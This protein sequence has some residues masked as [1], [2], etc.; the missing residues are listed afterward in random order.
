MPISTN[1]TIIA[2]LAGGLYNQTLSSATYDEV[3]SAV[4]TVADINTWANSLV[5]TDFAGRTDAQIAT[6][7]L[8]NLGLTSVAGLNNWVAAQI[9]AAGASGKGAKIVSLLNDFSNLASDP[10]YGAAASSFNTKVDA[11]LALSQTVDFKGGDLNAAATI[12]AAAKAAAEKA[13]AEAAA[14]KAAAEKAAAEKAAADK[15]AAEKAAAEAAAAKAAAE[16]AA[17]EKAAA[18]KAA[19][20]KAAAEAAA[21]KAAAEKAA[22]EKAAADKAAAEKAAAEA[23]AAKAAAE[24]AAADKAA[25]EKAAFKDFSFTSSTKDI[26]NGTANADKL[27]GVFSSDDAL[28]TIDSGDTVFDAT[29]GDGDTLTIT[30]DNDIDGGAYTLPSLTNIENLVFKVDA[31]TTDTGATFGLDVS[32]AKGQKT[33]NVDV[34][35][36]V[37]GINAVA[38]DGVGDGVAV[39]TGT[40]FK[41]VEITA[42]NASNDVNV[43]VMAAGSI[44]APVILN[45]DTEGDN[46]ITAAGHI[47]VTT[48]STGAVTLTAAKS[49]TLDAGDA[50]VV[51]AT[52]NGGNLSVDGSS[53]VS[54]RATATGDVTIVNG[55]EG[56]LTVT[57]TAGDVT[58]EDAASKDTSVT[59]K[60]DISFDG[61]TTGDLNLTAGGDVVVGDN[62]STESTDVTIV[63][64]GSVDFDGINGEGSLTISAGSDVTIISSDHKNVTVTTTD[65]GADVITNGGGA[66]KITA[67]DD[68][69]IIATQ[70][71]VTVTTT[72]D[73][74][75]TSTGSGALIINAAG[76][77]SVDATQIAVTISGVGV[78]TLDIDSA[79]NLTVSGAG[80]VAEFDVT[81]MAALASVT[82]TGSQNITLELDAADRDGDV[83]KI[84]DKSTGILTVDLVSAGSVDLRASD[85]IDSLILSAS[86]ATETLKLASGQ[87]VNV[88]VD[89][90]AT[91][92]F[93]VGGASAVAKNTLTLNLDDT[94]RDA[95]AVDLSG[96]TV[97]NARTITINTS[98]DS[99][100]GGLANP[101]TITSFNASDAKANVT[102]NAGANGVTLATAFDVGSA[103]TLTIKSS[104]AVGVGATA[105]TAA[106][107]DASAATGKVTATTLTPNVAVVKTGSAG[108]ALTYTSP[109]NI[110]VESG[111]G[112]DTLKLDNDSYNNKSVSIN[113]G[114]GAGDTLVLDDGTVLTKG[115]GSITVTGVE[116]IRV[117]ASTSGATKIDA[118]LLSAQTYALQ[119]GN[120]S[121]KADLTLTAVVSSSATALDFTTLVPSTALATAFGPTSSSS[122]STGS[123]LAIDANAN[124]AAISIKGITGA[125]NSI[126]GSA[127]AGDTL[128]GGSKDDTFTYSNSNLLFAN[129]ALLDSIDGGAG[130]DTL[131]VTTGTIASTDSF[132]GLTSVEKFTGGSASLTFGASAETAGLKSFTITQ[133]ANSS[134]STA[135]YTTVGTTVSMSGAFK[136]TVTTGAA[137]DNVTLGSAVTAGSSAT[138]GDGDDTITISSVL[139]V[140]VNGGSGSDTFNFA[141]KDGGPTSTAFAQTATS[142]VGGTGSDTLIFTTTD[143]TAGDDA[144]TVDE[145]SVNTLF[146]NVTSV[147]T[148]K[149]GS[150]TSSAITL[151]LS[152]NAEAAG[153]RTVDISADTD[154]TG[155][156]SIDLTDFVSDVTVVGSSGADTIDFG[157]TGTAFVTAGGG[158]D[159]INLDANT[160][161][162]TVVLGA[163]A[164]ANGADDINGFEAGADGDIINISAFLTGAP[165]IGNA[166]GSDSIIPVVSSSTNEIQLNGRIAIVD[167][168][169]LLMTASQI[170][171]I[172]NGASDNA[173]KWTAAGKAVLFVTDGSATEMW[174][175][176]SSLAGAASTVS[177][178]D[179]KL[180]GTL[181]GIDGTDLVSSNIV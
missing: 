16:K 158:D 72:G 137:A 138:S 101:S 174:Y 7:L 75:V 157:D 128:V 14:A 87:A 133:L 1:G 180:V 140:S 28:N 175:I 10:T 91:T 169:A 4:K 85:L 129:K 98:A 86:F 32:D 181:I 125:K 132:A 103:G 23:A 118:A 21:A 39:T 37:T 131:T 62:I 141:I 80:D 51:I 8:T 55:G 83:I 50:A 52:A 119:T 130:N 27:T 160:L 60:G 126:T 63:A 76:E 40:K 33:I 166:T 12:A 145:S 99:G 154:K 116:T 159:E 113:M 171:A 15:A 45:V 78:S 19:A 34:V 13:A 106:L 24:K 127:A 107:L 134:I 43:N 109:G 36:T 73:V 176:D 163:T 97:E 177:V 20:E 135:A 164:E 81:D 29:K 90:A 25:A 147:E 167:A 69:T 111:A 67:T 35:R 170:L 173:F 89:Q 148:L 168:G 120:G 104:G 92:T 11:A 18:D 58:V 53:A 112:N 121:T 61:A 26:F 31:T 93:S 122:T 66:L 153:I 94:K 108:D 3:V 105:V 82:A 84:Q 146:N 6:V 102:I 59:A 74:D 110:T 38:I 56:D 124:S 88:A 65:G 179:I 123:T 71:N 161:T 172:I 44:S 70:K 152:S 156:N 30:T 49:A 149:V 5:A 77:H 136:A 100:V 142:V 114:D 46:V 155:A 47:N 9:T 41:T 17:A 162:D 151:V 96:V 165:I 95:A 144:I 178:D 139:A 22:A 115:T 42:A 48:D 54:V 150:A 117:E 79:K 64:G 143:D 57:S 2:R 68:V